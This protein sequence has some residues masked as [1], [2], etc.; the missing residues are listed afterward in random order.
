MTQGLYLFTFKKYNYQLSQ[1]L[2]NKSTN[3]T[4]ISNFL[5][6]SKYAFN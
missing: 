3:F 4:E 6:R 2:F 5:Y 1:A